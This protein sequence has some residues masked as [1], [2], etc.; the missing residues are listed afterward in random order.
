MDD[1]SDSFGFISTDAPFPLPITLGGTGAA[2]REVAA[3]NIIGPSP[4][5]NALDE[6]DKVLI[7]QNS[8][9]AIRKR[10]ADAFA[11]DLWN[12]LYKDPE[13][14]EDSTAPI[15]SGAVY[16]AL[17]GIFS[18]VKYAEPG[19]LV[20]I[21]DGGYNQPVQ[22]MRIAINPVQSGEG[23]P[24]PDNVRPISGWTAAKITRTGANLLPFPYIGT[25]T[26]PGTYSFSGV[27]VTVNSDGTMLL[28]GT[29]SANIYLNLTWDDGTKVAVP[30]PPVGTLLTIG[31]E[32]LASGVTFI[33][34]IFTSPNLSTRRPFANISNTRPIVSGLEIADGDYYFRSYIQ[35]NNGTVCN[36]VLIKP[37][38]TLGNTPDATFEPYKGTTYEVSFG[39]AGTIYG[40]TLTYNGDGTWELSVDHYSFTVAG[41][42]VTL[43]TSLGNNL[44]TSIIYIDSTVPTTGQNA[45]AI[46]NWLP[47]VRANYSADVTGFYF[48][49]D[50]GLYIKVPVSAVG[51]TTLEATK[52]YFDAHPLII[53]YPL[54]TPL[55]YTLTGPEVL[56]LLGINNIWADTG[57]IEELA[58]RAD[59]G[60]YLVEALNPIKEMLAYRED[61]MKATRAYTTGDY[62]VVGDTFYKAATAIANGAILTPN[63]NVIKTTVG[64][65]L[66]ALS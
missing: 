12:M 33:N 1:S 20:H 61:T 65:Q 32:G 19:Q 58:Y 15:T 16:Q 11:L 53:V 60:L 63:T 17:G 55:T 21:E 39:T 49:S 14:I 7:Q 38:F 41:D 5:V 48:Y 47:R 23:D 9:A 24:S 50:R 42:Q 8:T 62:I 25:V 4:A 66:K 29:A 13:P 28:N 10:R 57:D 43:V 30:V 35:I 46:S 34:G 6:Y 2:N 37:F 45:P 51:D 26:G 22:G 18:P 56:T 52:S 44:R 40:G 3:M 36:N 27:T 59:I 54:A 64:D 31:C